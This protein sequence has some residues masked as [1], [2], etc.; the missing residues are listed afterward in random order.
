MCKFRNLNPDECELRVAQSGKTKDGRVWAQYLIY[1]D[2]RVD[3]RLLDE[4]VG[5]LRWQK[6]YE[7]LDGKL[8]CTVSIWDDELKTWVG[9]QDVGTESNTEKEK[10][11]ASD[12]FKRACFN[13]GIGRELYTAPDIY[14]D[15]QPGEYNEREGKVYPKNGLF[16]VS[17]MDVDANKRITNLVITDRRGNVRF[18][19]RQNRQQKPAQKQQTNREHPTEAQILAMAKRIAAGENITDKIQ[20]NFL[21]SQQE[22]MWLD[23]EIKKINPNYNTHENE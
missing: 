11:Q 23:A 14:I 7:F 10:G 15:L 21:M 18:P 4:T 16:S 1:K 5:P 17:V 9:K 8:Y 2:A 12:A 13:W 6:S 20:T 19:A 3:Q 22:W